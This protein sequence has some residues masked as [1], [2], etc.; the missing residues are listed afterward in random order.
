MICMPDILLVIKQNLSII[1][2]QHIV[3][4][5]LLSVG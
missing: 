2:Q 3:I 5:K 4:N 1:G